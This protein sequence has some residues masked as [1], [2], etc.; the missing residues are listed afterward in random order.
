MKKAPKVGQ[1]VRF[2]GSVVVGPCVGV[3]EKIYVRHTFNE[4][5]SDEWN[6]LNG[7]PLPESEWHVRMKP[8]L[9]PELWCY[10][11]ND[12]FAPP[13]SDLEPA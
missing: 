4:E 12:C 2:K 7:V 1:R 13:V 3:I 8:D 10:A 9:L 5:M 11:G 6:A